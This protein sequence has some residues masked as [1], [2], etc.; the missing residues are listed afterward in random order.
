MED[1]E[2]TNQKNGIGKAHFE[3]QM[4]LPKSTHSVLQITLSGPS[5]IGTILGLIACIYLFEPSFTATI[6][7]LAP[8]P[9][10]VIND[11]K[12]FLSLGPGGTP[13]TFTGYLKISC[14][15][16]CAI[17]DPFS[18][19]YIKDLTGLYPQHGLL[20]ASRKCLPARQGPRPQVCGIAPQ[21]QVDQYG[22]VESYRR[23]R[24]IL[25]KAGRVDARLKTGTSCFEK[26]GLALF[27]QLPVNNTCNG[28]ICHVHDSD[29]SF[30]LNLHP[31]DAKVVLDEGWGQRHPLADGGW[32]GRCVPREFTMIYAPRDELELEVVLDIVD[33]AGWW[34]TGE[35]LGIA[36]YS[37]DLRETAQDGFV[38]GQLVTEGAS[39]SSS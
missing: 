10:I 17:S 3:T 15:R 38:E 18:P 14:L 33:A 24:N 35:V 36:S 39:I 19:P 26:Q 8:L 25:L 12:A 20:A 21:R 27:A 31:E 32:F 2:L 13:S 11:F 6:I 16:L 1:M 7:A 9:L 34:V 28:E 4:N 5:L 30:H 22:D 29:K 37:K 23:F